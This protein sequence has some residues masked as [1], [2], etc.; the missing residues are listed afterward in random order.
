M[1]IILTNLDRFTKFFTGRFLSKFA[2]KCILKIQP[3][4][5]NSCQQ[6]RDVK[7]SKPMWHRGQISALLFLASASISASWHLASASEQLALW[8]RI[9]TVHMTLINIHNI[10][11]DNHLLC[12]GC[13]LKTMFWTPIFWSSWS[14]TELFS[15]VSGLG[16]SLI[17]CDVM[18]CD[19]HLT[20]SKP[21]YYHISV[22]FTVSVHTSMI[23]KQLAPSPLPL[24]TPSSTTATLFITTCPTG[25]GSRSVT[26]LANF[27]SCQVRPSVC[28]RVRRN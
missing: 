8:P 25:R 28:V 7:A 2:V 26:V 18:W 19:E 5:K 15:N 13:L 17:H 11:I 12:I 14:C 22:S 1:T 4:H 3:C 20:F 27:N 23:P 10:A 24:F 6:N 21:C 9:F 16:L